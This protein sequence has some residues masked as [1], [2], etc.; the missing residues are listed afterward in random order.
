MNF[1]SFHFYI[2][3]FIPDPPTQIM[4]NES[5]KSNLAKTVDSWTAGGKTVKAGLEC[6][7]DIGSSW[8]KFSPKFVAAAYQAEARSGPANK[9]INIATFG[10]VDL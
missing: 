7:G 2:S 8:S 6:Q 1:D 5:I 9:S 4:F 3:K 10:N